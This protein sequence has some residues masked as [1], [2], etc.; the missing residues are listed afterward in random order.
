M[1]H[2]IAT[3]RKRGYSS[4]PE[5]FE[6]VAPMQGT[7]TDSA[8][9]QCY[10]EINPLK[11]FLVFAVAL[12]ASSAAAADWPRFHGPNNDNISPD[13][14]LL[15]SWPDGG[16]ERIWE[17]SGIGEG[18]S[19]VAIVGDTIYTTGEIDGA[20][21]ITALDAD[22]KIVWQ[23]KNGEAWAKS[24]PGTRSTPT[25]HE[26]LLYHLSANGNLICLKAENGDVVWTVNIIEKFEGKNI[27]WGLSESLLIVDDKVICS[28][29]GTRAGT[30]A[31][32]RMT[33]D[34]VWESTGA[35]GGPGYASPTLVDYQGLQQIVMPMAESIVGVRVSD[36]KLLWRHPHKVYTNQNITNPLFRDGFIIISACGRQGTTSLK[37]NVSGDECSIEQHWHNEVLDDK[38]GGLI[39]VDGRIYGY[40]ESQQRS[41]PWMC[42][43]F[44][45]G[46]TIFQSAPIE[47]SYK[48]RNGS[49]AYADGMFYLYTDDGAMALVKPSDDGFELKGMLE[50]EDPGKNPTWSHPVIL[51]GRLYLRYGDKLAVYNVR[52]GQ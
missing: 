20:C 38:H 23:E 48:Y 21:V 8:Q 35:R 36:G 17:S 1:R 4:S 39:L 26:G 16:P 51:N 41:E 7:L 49:L 30:V 42:I 25:I 37:L 29:G 15:K 52:A 47:S 31:L 11:Q 19:S 13:T 22:G 27:M 46:A 3:D 43:D 40:A 2:A 6:S 50:I 9:Y 44:E 14:G 12:V 10:S 32:D 28:P 18:Y 5:V 45:T 34:T 24:Y 33:G